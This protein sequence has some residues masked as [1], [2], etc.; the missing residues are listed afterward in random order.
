MS[1][2]TT[3]APAV[4]ESSLFER[5]SDSVNPILVKET[6]QA[7][8]GRY[9]RISFWV[10]LLG[11]TM[12]GL[13][14]LLVMRVDG[15]ED[16]MGVVFFGVLYAFM[17]LATH[18]LVP[19]S[20]FL[21]MGAEWDENTWDLLT[22]SNLRPRQI[23][24]GK[25]LSAGVQALLYYSAFAPFLVFAFLLR[26]VDVSVI[27]VDL[28]ISLVASL[29]LSTFAVA[30]SSLSGSRFARVLLMVFL[31]STLVQSSFGSAAFAIQLVSFPNILSD[32]EFLDAIAAA[33][34]IGV[35]LTAFFFA[36]AIARLSHPEE[37]GSTALRLTSLGVVVVG[38]GWMTYIAW[39]SGSEEP[40]L[41]A[42]CLAFAVL[43]LTGLL[44]TTERERLGH[45]VEV[46]LGQRPWLAWLGLPL[47]PGGARGLV[48]FLLTGALVA[49][50]MHGFDALD[51]RLDLQPG[52]RLVPW[53]LLAYGF[54]HLGLVSG[55]LSGW[56][57]RLPSRIVA[58]AATVILFLF[59]LL[60]PALVGFLFGVDGW[61]EFE[62]PLNLFLV[63][64][65]LWSGIL[66]GGPVLLVLTF[67][68]LLTLI[69]NAPRLW[70]MVRET[71]GVAARGAAGS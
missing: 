12:L 59:S 26:G 11:A 23:V 50:W 36:V 2:A 14:T 62:H 4:P 21:S 65:D 37:N 46:T 29:L 6:R 54:L 19:F 10:T 63:V 18:V 31:A 13:T 35:A 39:G 44:F 41:V 66:P 15:G 25:V 42:V 71:A 55:L 45:R 17:T 38:L 61:D 7:L 53:V 57:E 56:S 60:L 5:L 49:A 3:T 8:R 28:A 52:E 58:R 68:G 24:L 64:D 20:A 32:P 16:R 67:G 34:T 30:L 70:R 1:E 27:G 43:A 9:F 51:G 40:V 22:L 69:V 33:L 48:F 47:L